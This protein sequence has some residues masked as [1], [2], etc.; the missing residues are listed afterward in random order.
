MTILD[1]RQ[2][3][4][5]QNTDGIKPCPNCRMPLEKNGACPHMRCGGHSGW[6]DRVKKGLACGTQFCWICEQIY[7]PN[8]GHRCNAAAAST[9]RPSTFLAPWSSAAPALHAT[10]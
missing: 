8:G 10:E 5:G 6:Q 4:K 1:S 2:A 7:P 3:A 9:A